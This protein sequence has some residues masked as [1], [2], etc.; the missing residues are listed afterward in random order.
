MVPNLEET[1][2]AEF[3]EVMSDDGYGKTKK[4]IKGMVES[5]ARDKGV[6]RKESI[7]DGWSPSLKGNLS[8]GCI[9]ETKLPL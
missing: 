1:N 2:L 3:L 9:R 6:L 8:L 5:A 4:Q 7:S